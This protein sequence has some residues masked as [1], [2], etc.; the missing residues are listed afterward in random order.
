MG[1]HHVAIGT[2]RFVEARALIETKGFRHIDLHVVDEVAVPDRLE[3]A[4]G[5][6][7]RQDVLRR[8]FAEEMIDSEDPVLGEHL[9]KL[10]IER[11]CTRQIGP[12][13]FFH[14]DPGALDEPRFGQQADRR[15]GRTRRHAQI[16]HEAALAD[17][18][19]FRPV[20][21]RLEHFGT[22]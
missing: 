2:G 22:C 13:R 20:D 19:G 14:D 12:E 9:V 7:E 16:V 6:P 18:G 1:H 8:L 4:V 17:E 15:K 21:R 5:E 10:G 3:Q 11:H